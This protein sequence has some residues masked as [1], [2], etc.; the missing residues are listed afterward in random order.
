MTQ[1]L[2]IV[3]PSRKVHKE[4]ICDLFGKAFRGN[5]YEMVRYARRSY[6]E[7][8]NYDWDSSRVGLIGDK[9]VTHFGIWDYQMR[10]GS[11]RVRCAGIGAVMT[12]GMYRKRGYMAETVRSCLDAAKDAGYDMT[13][14]FGLH[15]FYHKFGYVRAWAHTTYTLEAKELPTG[16]APR[17]TRF[18]PNPAKRDDLDRLYNR[19]YRRAT[20][21]AV[22][23]TYRRC[24]KPDRWQGYLWT[25]ARGKPAG[26]VI[27]H[28]QKGELVLVENVGRLD[29][30][31]AV[32]GVLARRWRCGK[33]RFD[34]LSYDHPLAAWAR[35]GNCETRTRYVRS[36]AAMVR[37]VNLRSTLE[38]IAGELSARLRRSHLA[39]WRGELLI[40]DP[41]EKVVLAIDRGKVEVADEPRPGRATSAVRGGEH[42]AQLLIG[43][44]QPAETA[45]AGRMR[46]SGDAKA[47]LQV[48]FPIQHPMLGRWDRY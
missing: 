22:R 12:D 36:G 27:A 47:L 32:L 21:T 30:V 44:D 19:E 20:G 15:N 31:L 42:I 13:I 34:C 43:T 38:K 24:P 28:P 10:V 25:D 2:M 3:P 48:L 18:R 17:T 4:A 9:L 40:S 1:K 16:A 8:S 37:T 45:Q 46:L 39:A 33:V 7:H 14:L 35:R 41:R 5:Y 23:P 11:G 6:F 26:Y 29:E